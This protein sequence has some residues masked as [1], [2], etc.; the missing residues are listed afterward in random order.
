MA[1]YIG[2]CAAAL[3]HFKAFAKGRYKLCPGNRLAGTERS[4][5]IA[6]EDFQFYQSIDRFRVPIPGIH[7]LKM[8]LRNRGIFC[9]QIIQRLSHLCPGH[10]PAGIETGSRFAGHIRFV[11]PHPQQWIRVKLRALRVL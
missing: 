5:L 4:V 10:V 6:A 8:I 3:C 9:Q 2:E 7:I 11:A 1:L